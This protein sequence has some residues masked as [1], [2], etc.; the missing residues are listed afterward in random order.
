VEIT[1]NDICKEITAIQ[2]KKWPIKGNLVSRKLSV[3]YVVLHKLEAANWVPTNHTSTIAIGLGRFIYI[4]GTKINFNFGSYVFKQT[5]KHSQ[6]FAIKKSIAFQ[7]LICAIIRNQ[8]PGILVSADVASRREFP[9]NF[10]YKL[11]AGS[12]VPDIVLTS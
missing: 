3:K 9:L 10:H 2:V 6:T 1:H 5:V 7:S 4:V 8:H 11:L 12:H